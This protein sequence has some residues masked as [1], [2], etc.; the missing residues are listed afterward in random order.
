MKQCTTEV[1][2]L[3]IESSAA[4]RVLGGSPSSY[5]PLGFLPGEFSPLPSWPDLIGLMVA[6]PVDAMAACRL[7]PSA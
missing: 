6:L 7:S 4:S 5:H 2:K 1:E 3:S